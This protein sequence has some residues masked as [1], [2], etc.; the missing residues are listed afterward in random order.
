MRASG[1]HFAPGSCKGKDSPASIWTNAPG[2]E[3]G[4]IIL[5]GYPPCQ[6]FP[7]NKSVE[8]PNPNETL[9]DPAKRKEQ[10]IDFLRICREVDLKAAH[11]D[12]HFCQEWYTQLP[13]VW[14]AFKQN[15]LLEL[16]FPNPFNPNN[17]SFHASDGWIG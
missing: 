5:Q 16:K 4:L 10:C 3:D 11:C 12:V 6:Q 8:G 2:S 17:F 14:N 15:R 1:V 13:D 9:N 7:I